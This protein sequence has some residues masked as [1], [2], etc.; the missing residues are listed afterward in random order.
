[1]VK[2]PDG[3]LFTTFDKS[4]GLLEASRFTPIAGLARPCR[5]LRS[6]CALGK[7]GNVYFGEYVANAERGP[8]RLYR[9]VP[10]SPRVDLVHTF[11][12]GEVRHVH[13]IYH[14][15]YTARLW[16]VTGDVGGECRILHSGDGFQSFETQGEGDESWRTVSLAFTESAVYFATDAQFIPNVIYRLD[17]ATGERETLGRIDGPV[18]VCR[19]IGNEIFFAV[20][21]ELCPSQVGRSAT[22]WHVDGCGKVSA[23]TSFPKDRLHV[24]Y[25]MMG[26]LH[27]PLGPGERHRLYLHGVGLEGADDRTF[28]VER[29]PG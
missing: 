9:Y 27:L 16:C 8:I 18:Y 24:D 14:D 1:V 6:A 23:L 17:R 7:D 22:L 26:T 29:N 20:T 13:G 10:G 15:P 25:F 4:I 21:A 12:A 5:V 2:L 19:A 3:R 11:P 28:V